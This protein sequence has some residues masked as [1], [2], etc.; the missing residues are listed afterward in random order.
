VLFDAEAFTEKVEKGGATLW[1][2]RFAGFEGGEAQQACNSL[3]RS[4][5]ACFAQRI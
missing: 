1:R 2:A 3:K 4:G 5:F